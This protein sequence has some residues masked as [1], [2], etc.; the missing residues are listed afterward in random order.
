MC[1]SANR[2]YN[3]K[4]VCGNASCEFEQPVV[5][6]LAAEI[7]RDEHEEESGHVAEI[8]GLDDLEFHPAVTVTRGGT[9]HCPDCFAVVGDREQCPRCD[10]PTGALA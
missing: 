5:D 2:Q 9:K 6:H 1:P 7:F 4:T 3:F 10:R 8:V